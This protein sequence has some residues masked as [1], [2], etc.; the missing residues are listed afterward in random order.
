MRAHILLPQVVKFIKF[1]FGFLSHS[2]EKISKQAINSVY[3]MILTR[4]P[5]DVVQN[6]I[7]Q[8]GEFDTKN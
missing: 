7:M 3:S 4:F 2:D 1:S 6:C 8:F 5:I